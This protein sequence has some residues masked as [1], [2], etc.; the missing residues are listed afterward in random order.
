MILPW[1][2]SSGPAR[3]RASLREPG[4]IARERRRGGA[5]GAGSR[6]R[7]P[8]GTG[9]RRGMRRGGRLGDRAQGTL[10]L[11]DLELQLGERVGDALVH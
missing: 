6:G 10:E 4:T 1:W 7:E 9:P 8:S 5:A 2:A 3:E 11:S